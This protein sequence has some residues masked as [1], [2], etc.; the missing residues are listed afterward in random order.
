MWTKK[1]KGI[2]HYLSLCGFLYAKTFFEKYTEASDLHRP[3]G[4]LYWNEK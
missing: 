3:F 4:L 2:Y 1:V